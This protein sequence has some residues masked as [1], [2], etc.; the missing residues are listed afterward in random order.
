MSEFDKLEEQVE[1]GM[2]GGN[3]GVPTGFHRLG[4]HMSIR[5]RIMATIFG[6]TGSGKTAFVHSAFVLNP[7]DW[8]IRMMSKPNPSKIRLKIPIFSME[9]SKLYTQMKWTSRKVFLDQGV[10]IPLG[11]LMGWEGFDRLTKDE[12]DLFLMT[13]DYIDGMEGII[14]IIE[15]PQN[16]TGIYKYLKNYAFEHGHEEKIDEHHKIYVPDNPEE[17]VIPIADHYGLSKKEGDMRDKK[18]AI[19]KVSE[20]FQWSRDYLGYS[21]VGVSQLT[22]NLN[23]PIYQKMDSFE[24]T[25]D[26]IKESGRPGEDSDLVISIFDPIRYHT[27]DPDYTVE[28]F[29]DPDTGGKYFRSVKILKNSYGEDDIRIGMGFQGATGIFAELP[30]P[31]NM[32]NFDYGSLVDGQYF[33]DDYNKTLSKK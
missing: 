9:R 30:K 8:Y 25:I 24:P 29:R 31:S 21:P 22:R 1:L 14:D 4:K 27:S 18:Q 19:D 33:I 11:K 6:P 3:K 10:L 26:D 5:K 7:Y 2:A 28:N 32:E 16:P 13:R 23:N 20:Y 12:H 15:G 17:I